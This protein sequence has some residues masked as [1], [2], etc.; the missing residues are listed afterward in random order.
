[1]LLAQTYLLINAMERDCGSNYEDNASF[2]SSGGFAMLVFRFI[3]IMSFVLIAFIGN[4]QEQSKEGPVITVEKVDLERYAGKWYEISKLPNRFQRQCIADT[5]AE[6]AI[7][8]DGRIDVI[9]RCKKKGNAFDEARGVARIVDTASNAKL[10]VSFVRFLWRWWFWG[11]YWIIGLGRDYDY[12]IV[13]TPNRKY[14]WVLSRT[15]EMDPDL[16]ETISEELEKQGYNPLDFEKTR[17][18]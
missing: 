12:A 6:Y 3:L 17:H 15:P 7:R 9:N 5:T 13:G 10:K 16:Y 8:A 4:A 14:G 1:M 11:D 18:Q 2:L